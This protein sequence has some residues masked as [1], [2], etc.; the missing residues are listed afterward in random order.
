M[1][2]KLWKGQAFTVSH[3]DGTGIATGGFTG[4]LRAFFEYRD[5]GIKDATSGK[6]AA[7]VIRAVPAA[8]LSRTGIFMSWI[9]R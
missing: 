6:F 5:L 9:S 1:A 8:M 7:H 2:S 4:G 3:A